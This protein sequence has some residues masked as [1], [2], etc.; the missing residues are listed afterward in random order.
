MSDL[1]QRIANLSPA[2]R[3]LLNLRLE[4]KQGVKEP[5]AIIGMGCRFP[6][7]ALNPEAFW[8][9]L[10]DGVDTITEIPKSRW[11]VDTYYD[12]DPDAPG[13]MYTRSAGFLAEVDKFD[14]AFFG[15][16]PREAA[17][18]DP[19][20]RLL[21][22]V[23]W[24]AL[25]NAGQ[26]PELLMS[27]QT[28][29]FVGICTNDYLQRH[30]HSG[31]TSRIDAYSYTGTAFSV[32]V[33]RLSYLLGLQ[34][35]SIAVDTAC[36][37]SLVGLHLA[38][39]SLR[40]GESNL[41]LAGGVNLIL[42]PDNT[43]YF[44]KVRA[45]ATDGHCK[46]FDADADGYARGEGCG[47]VVLKR[48]SDALRDGDNILAL[49][50]GTAV[51]QD[52]RSN[53]LTAPNGP[54]QQAVIRQALQQ[55]G[56]QP[57]Q[58][59][60]VEAHGTGTPLGDPIEFESLKAVLMTS[61]EHNQP[62]AIGSVKTNIGHLE[63]AAGIAGLIKVVLS[64][65][66]REIPP[67]LNLKQ[68]N[69]RIS[70]QGT[71][72]SIPL[73]LQPWPRALER[74]FAGISSFSF[75]G[76]NAHVVVE[77]APVI[78]TA[79]SEVERPLHLLTLSAKSGNALRVL[80]R[81]YAEFLSPHAVSLAD[82]CFTANTGR[83]HL[84]HRLTTTAESTTQLQKQLDVFAT[85]Q[86][87]TGLFVGQLQSKNRPKIAFLFTGQGSVYPGMGRQLYETQP[88]FRR[89]L[90]QCDELL[91]TELEQPLL[92]VI[93]PTSDASEL[94]RTE[95]TQPALFALEYALA[96]LWR[97]WGVV[98]DAVMGHSVGEYVAACIAGVFNLEDGLRLIAQRG[99]LLQA[100]PQSGEMVAVFAD[101]MRVSAAIAMYKQV[102]IAA[103]NGP[104]NIVI[105]GVREAVQAV[106]TDLLSAG[107][108]VQ[109][110]K[111]SHAFHSPLMDPILNEFELIAQKLQFAAPNIPLIS[112]LSGQMLNPG[113][114]PDANYWRRH[115]RLPVQFSA[116]M[117]TLA[118]QG[119]STFVELGPQPVLL[120]M[121]KRC[122]PQGNV[123]WLPSLKKEQSDW[124]VLLDSV[125]ALC[126]K[127]QDVDWTG[128]D[129]DYTRNRIPLPTYPW[130]RQRYWIEPP[131][132]A[133]VKPIQVSLDKKSDVADWFYIPKWQQSTPPWQTGKQGR[134]GGALCPPTAETR[135]EKLC[136]L[137]FV[138]ECGL[139]DQLVKQLELECQ[140][141]ITV[142]VAE[143]F[144]QLSERKYTLNPQQ[145]EH[146]DA[147]L[148]QL[149]AQN[150]TPKTIVHLWNVT[151]S[152]N[153]P[154]II[155]DFEKSH[156]L[157][158]SSL[159]F[160]AQALGAQ[161]KIDP[162]E[163]AVVSNNLQQVTGVEVLCP[164]KATLLGPCKVIPQEYP[165][166]TCR[167]IDVV[168]PSDNM[169]EPMIEQLLAELTTTTSDKVIAH[170]Q[171][172][173]WVQAFESVRLDAAVPGQTKLRTGGV[174]LIT[175]GLGGIGLVLAEYL[176]S[177]WQ[178]KLILVGRKALPHADEWS[179]W[180]ATHS[181]LDHT[182]LK[183][184]QVQALEQMGA[185]VLV[186]S[187][188][189]ANLEQM[190]AAISKAE[191]RFG[192]VH[193]VIHAAG[194]AGGGV[195]QLKTP[196]V[197]ASV[198]APKV[199]GTLVLEQIFQD[200][201]LD[202]FVLT[203]SINSIL[204]E[205]GQ[206]DYC[207]ANTFLDAFAHYNL[208]KRGTFTVAINWDAWREVGMAVNTAVTLELKQR[209]D[210][211]LENGISSQE[212]A[213]AF[214]RILANTRTQVVVSTQDLQ[215]RIEH[216]LTASSAIEKLE[217]S[218]LPKPTY[219]RPELN[220][221]YVAPRNDTEQK[222]ATIWQQILGLAQV[223]INDNFFELGG[224]SLIAVSLFAQIKQIFNKNL[225]LATLF[226]AATVEQQASLLQ[227]SEKS[228]LWSSLVAIQ[229]AGSKPPLFCIGGAG[230][231]VF[232]FRDLSNHLSL[233]QPVYGLQAQGLD[234]KQAPHTR[235]EDMAAHYIK[236]LRTFQSNG[237][238]FLAGHSVGGIV[239]FEMAQQLQMQGQKVGLLA[240]F[241]AEIFKSLDYVPSFWD[242]ASFHLSNLIELEPNKK[243]SYVSRMLNASFKS[244][245]QNMSK[246]IASLV[247]VQS[248]H[249][250]NQDLGGP[251]FLPQNVRRIFKLNEQAARD[252]LPQVYPGQVTFFRATN[253]PMSATSRLR[254]GQLAAGGLEVH[255]VPG[256]HSF[257]DSLLSE[258]HV[259]VLAEKLQPCLDQAQANLFTKVRET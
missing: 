176:A 152:T 237:P 215:T 8:Q 113:E 255:K 22:E 65:Q 79:A 30:M 244:G 119:Y 144:S 21:L 109:P 82:V 128:F 35:P 80:A 158:F 245:V 213:D 214:S 183:I 20:Q 135:G 118:E 71:P 104:E 126:V 165:H 7:D 124:Q 140:D 78:I 11:D 81:R 91:R 67:H 251:E 143:Q 24:E 235:I 55:A 76:T 108:T 61:R 125:G 171:E 85:G 59:S 72:I 10:R 18:M 229:P 93:Y 129:Q 49:L 36:S 170:R 201:P 43:I 57:A 180:L 225:P 112:N 233:E 26:S 147:L 145:S 89:A 259:R 190:Q 62:C 242:K 83:S 185:E 178:A 243:L 232:Y 32:A 231:D 95:Y 221:A 142:M 41:A 106:V 205:F 164:Q 53:G 258:P 60:Y 92:S 187:A 102:A 141:V 121:G 69:P 219:S 257:T 56:V 173:R 4:I 5:I 96:Q 42:A 66:H 58:I 239:A 224:D 198:I 148:S 136:W 46:T 45:L 100:L 15:I 134:K 115:V 166:I 23:S 17:S 220:N 249:S 155:D 6:G 84:T 48:L 120:N 238:Y 132:Q 248:Q 31:D 182:S 195:I 146:Y 230:G 25:E 64:M 63:P 212:G 107:I 105:S 133:E 34:G 228:E 253:N 111:V 157:G 163:I 194:I 217:E 204:G 247:G 75:S 127:G 149:D 98:P 110:L 159:L 139:G 209:R 216:A 181:K 74:R 234:G 94:H 29:V 14:A 103:V 240:L 9:V 50:R 40:S 206:V 116:G 131:T 222:I 99:R 117:Q 250:L 197:A 169:L 28:G 122:L 160:L 196:E 39:Q 114:I 161:N 203:S 254:W 208:T 186:V 86:P 13:K 123:T 138:D 175:G 37:S 2:K 188:D 12:S 211:S 167:S 172:Q 252:Y 27:S 192:G 38:C 210:Q 191:Q 97:S 179:Q 137:V 101:Q 227:Q 68:L 150:L 184:Q 199:K 207:A 223:G 33:G 1:S 90:E 44:C 16:S 77:E 218:H 70:L 200:V 226:Q 189:V 3:E 156:S 236:E 51:N 246:K 162:L 168:M 151:P 87:T 154:S 241:D 52:G 174:Y 19:Q 153:T 202:F 54:A 177:T 88:T 47:M 256:D 193:G 73:E 130:E